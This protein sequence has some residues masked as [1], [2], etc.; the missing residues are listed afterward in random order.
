MHTYHVPSTESRPTQVRTPETGQQSHFISEEEQQQTIWHRAIQ[1]RTQYQG[2]LS[3]V[4]ASL[5]WKMCKDGTVK[6]LERNIFT[7]QINRKSRAEPY[8]P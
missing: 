1:R 8:T 4:V 5:E 2:A 3:A 6:C 7:R